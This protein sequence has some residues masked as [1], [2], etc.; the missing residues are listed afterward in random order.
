MKPFKRVSPKKA[1]AWGVEPG[2]YRLSTLCYALF[3]R[4]ATNDETYEIVK[5][6]FPDSKAAQ[7]RPQV[8]QYRSYGAKTGKIPRKMGR[9]RARDRKKTGPKPNRGGK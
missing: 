5:K 3:T 8:I 4:G 1:E 7:S 9:V 6:F 2:M